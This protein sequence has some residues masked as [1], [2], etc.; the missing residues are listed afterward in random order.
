M[1]DYE[2]LAYKIQY[3]EKETNFWKD[4]ITDTEESA[5]NYI[6]ENYKEWTNY[7]LIKLST[8]IIN[9]LKGDEE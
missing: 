1:L 6:K 5:I 4:H 7:R 8:A 3:S 2:I 9:F